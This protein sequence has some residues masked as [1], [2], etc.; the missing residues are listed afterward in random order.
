M[1]SRAS[2]FPTNPW[3]KGLGPEGAQVRESYTPP[4]R[5]YRAAKDAGMDFV[6][7]TDHET[8][9]GAEE[10][11]YRGDFF[12]GEEV[13]ALFPEDGSKVDVLVFG[14]GAEGHREAQSRR[15]DVYA[16]VDYLREA[17]LAHVLA[18]PTYGV[19]KN[20]DSAML[21]KRLLLFGLWE[22]V[23]GSRPARH[24]RLAR[25]IARRVGPADLRQLAARHGLPIPPHRAIGGT[26][27]SDDHGCLYI[28][29]AYTIGPTGITSPSEFLEALKAGEV[30]PAG[31]SGSATKLAHAGIRIAGHAL[32]ES[33]KVPAGG[34]VARL[35]SGALPKELAGVAGRLLARR[36]PGGA[37]A[38]GES[39]LPYVPLLSRLD[40]E[41][42][43]AALVSRYE[44]GVAGALRSGASGLPLVDLLASVGSLADAHLPIAP[45]VGVHAYFG[46]ENAKARALEREV[47]P[48][49]RERTKV[50]VFVDGLDD[51]LASAESPAYRDLAALAGAAAGDDEAQ[52]RLLR[53]AAGATG[54]SD[55]R[56]DGAGG[57]GALAALA[58]LPLPDGPDLGVPSLLEVLDH[59][60]EAEYTALH[61][62][63]PGPLGLAALVAG[64]VLGV[65]VVAAHRAG[66]PDYA[67]SVSGDAT[68]ADFVEAAARGFYERC[69]AVVVPNGEAVL[70][71][72]ARG[73]RVPLEALEGGPG[74]VTLEDFLALHA[75]VAGT[76]APA[77]RTPVTA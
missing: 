57:P 35:V 59:V 4:E 53:C 5:A 44:E 51:A 28:G 1:H 36:A 66:L 13:S 23:N 9:S 67:R 22:F 37:G 43:R 70:D 72:R 40:G 29:A 46:R 60:A 27:G 45:Y 8:I 34:A 25:D 33:G 3:V 6:T 41:G 20:L 21:E 62:A 48:R 64:L 61:V 18:H 49:R 26:A 7:L 2:G 65:P 76:E 39:L 68:V 30:S 71:L 69:A 17:G 12:V 50:G 54:A 77:P 63:A 19:P 52:V 56:A 42:M 10:L 47:L 15:G 58:T 75:R 32:E 24:N 14:L 73:Y 31:E 16:L 38:A 74:G 55:V 11:A